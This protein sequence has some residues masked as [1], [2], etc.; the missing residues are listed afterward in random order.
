MLSVAAT[1]AILAT[2][3]FACGLVGG[4]LPLRL[5]SSA[6]LSI[7]SAFGGGVFVAAGFVHLLP[8]AHNELDNPGEFPLANV[9]CSA[10]IL[11]IMIVE[12][13]FHKCAAAAGTGREMEL[14]GTGI[15]DS[16][17]AQQQLCSDAEP[18]SQSPDAAAE[19]SPT[20]LWTAITLFLGLSFHSLLAGLSLGILTDKSTVLSVFAAIVAHKS[21]AAFA[22]GVSLLR[23]RTSSGRALTRTQVAASIVA[24]SLVTPTGVML[25]TA[26]GKIADTRAAAGMT[27]AAAGTFLYVGLMEVAAKELAVARSEEAQGS[28]PPGVLAACC[29]ST[30]AKATAMAVGYAAM[31]ALA[32]WV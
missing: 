28:H 15:Y 9:I 22:L 1:N 18:G 27:A 29:S 30:V 24:F 16:D 8:D 6:F 19:Q 5:S 32:L 4:L 20:R 17:T 12:A 14:V 7:G 11:L 21:V 3:I 31:A 25:G 23:A 26:A 2:V 13:I 10:T